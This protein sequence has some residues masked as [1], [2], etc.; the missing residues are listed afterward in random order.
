MVRDSDSLHVENFGTREL[1]SVLDGA[2]AH[3]LVA[4]RIVDHV[5]DGI[6]AVRLAIVLIA[7]VSVLVAAYRK[8]E[9]TLQSKSNFVLD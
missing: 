7:L 3:F 4:N 1:V 8:S 5:L 6:V 9:K 2:L